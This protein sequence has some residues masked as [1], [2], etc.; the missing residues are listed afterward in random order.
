MSIKSKIVT[1][2]CPEV[3]VPERRKRNRVDRDDIS[4]E[5]EDDDRKSERS[6][7][8]AQQMRALS[9]REEFEKYFTDVKNLGSSTYT[10]EKGKKAKD[11]ILTKLGVA[12]VKQQKMPFK[13]RLGINEGRKRRAENMLKK[14]KDSGTVI[15]R[16]LMQKPLKK[17]GD[18]SR[19]HREELDTH[20]K[21]GVLHL[22]KNRL[23]LFNTSSST[24]KR[25]N[26]R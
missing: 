11:D 24:D 18:G 20:V 26:Y 17:L 5:G 14:S 23:A 6:F 16:S 7:K 3:K 21:G 22:S 9:D 2:K 13:M 10:G 12:K 15:A 1:V 19:N 25:R 4:F 8:G